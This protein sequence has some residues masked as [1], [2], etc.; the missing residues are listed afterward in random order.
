MEN[1]PEIEN[2][3]IYFLLCRLLCDSI[4]FISLDGNAALMMLGKIKN[5]NL[6]TKSLSTIKVSQNQWVSNKS[7]TKSNDM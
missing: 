3:Y 4:Y 1:D 7:K 2:I 6:K 5:N